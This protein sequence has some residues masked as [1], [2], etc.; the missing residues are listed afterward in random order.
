MPS[1]KTCDKN[2]VK[3]R[4]IIITIIMII[5][6]IIIMMVIIMLHLYSANFKV[7]RSHCA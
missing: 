3:V 2:T 4:F 1:L 7:V 5:I 6:K